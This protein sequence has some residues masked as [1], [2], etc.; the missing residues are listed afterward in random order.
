MDFFFPLSPGILTMLISKCHR[1]ASREMEAFTRTPLF[2]E[3]SSWATPP[4]S[5]LLESAFII[6]P[7]CKCQ[8]LS[9]PVS[10]PPSDL[11][12]HIK[13]RAGFSA[14]LAFLSV[15][16]PYFLGLPFEQ[17]RLMRTEGG[18]GDAVFT[19][20]TLPVFACTLNVRQQIRVVFYRSCRGTGETFLR[21]ACFW[22]RAQRN[23][24]EHRRRRWK[25]Q[26]TTQHLTSSGQWRDER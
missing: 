9:S 6:C 5:A 12:M 14:L 18:G 1:N 16:K 2:P 13:S 21:F 3:Q 19:E 4:A 20:S 22:R 26:K 10:P 7:T 15:C 24:W 8:R 17:C 23:W 25:K 11:T